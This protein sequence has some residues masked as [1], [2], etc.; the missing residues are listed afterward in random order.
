MADHQFTYPS[1]PVELPVLRA[2]ERE[3]RF[4]RLRGQ[5]P[6]VTGI[7]VGD[8]PFNR[9][10]LRN[11]QVVE[12]LLWFLGTW[13]ILHAVGRE[14]LDRF[15]DL[16][17]ASNQGAFSALIRRA[18]TNTPVAVSPMTYA[19]TVFLHAPLPDELF[20]PPPELPRWA[21]DREPANPY[22][23]ELAEDP[24]AQ[25]DRHYLEAQQ[26]DL[27]RFL[28]LE[29]QGGPTYRDIAAAEQNMIKARAARSYDGV[30]PWDESV[31]YP[32]STARSIA[33]GDIHKDNALLAHQLRAEVAAG[34]WNPFRAGNMTLSMA[35]FKKDLGLA[36]VLD[37]AARLEKLQLHA[38]E[39]EAAEAAAAAKQR[40]AELEYRRKHGGP[41]RRD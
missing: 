31:E 22:L 30:N 39:R 11:E 40:A 36:F 25:K 2:G 16:P 7:T 29:A 26:P 13:E 3:T 35:V 8:R 12:D 1:A 41:V 38:E 14:A 33:Q 17:A 5:L 34:R 27:A 21:G 23:E 10:I 37:H 28:R 15:G 32:N 24:R 19:D 6:N 20:R 9:R 4:T 18:I